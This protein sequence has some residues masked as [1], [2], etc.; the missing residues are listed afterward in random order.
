MRWD[1]QSAFRAKQKAQSLA[2]NR[3][4]RS[5]GFPNL[6]RAR[7]IYM[8]NVT[9]RRLARELAAQSDDT[10]PLPPK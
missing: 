5:K 9:A 7:A 1:S 10:I 3:F 2:R 4:W 6:V 8:A